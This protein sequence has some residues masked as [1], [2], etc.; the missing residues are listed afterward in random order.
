MGTEKD[1]RKQEINE[2]ERKEST[3]SSNLF[4]DRTRRL[5]SADTVRSLDLGGLDTE[6]EDIPLFV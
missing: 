4:L 3:S 5:S 1:E 2:D 6:E